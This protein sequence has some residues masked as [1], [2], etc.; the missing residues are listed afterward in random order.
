MLVKTNF[1]KSTLTLS[2]NSILELNHTNKSLC[3]SAFLM[4]FAQHG[5][6]QE[7]SVVQPENATT[8]HIEQAAKDELKAQVQAEAQTQN[9]S[10][11]EQLE[12]VENYQNKVSAPDSYVMLQ[13]Q[14]QHTDQIDTFKPITFDDL[15]ELPE[16]PID[17]N[18]ANEIYNVAKEAKTEAE[19]YRAGQTQEIVIRNPTSQELTEIN[20]APV[21]VD[22]LMNRIQAD[23]KIVV[24]ANESG[25]TLPELGLVTEPVVEEEKGFFKRWYH[26]LRPSKNDLET[27][28]VPRIKAEVIIVDAQNTNPDLP[29]KEYQQALLNLK[30]NVGAKLS[31]FTQEAYGDFNAALPQLKSLSNLSAQ[32]VGFYQAEFKFEKTSESRVKVSIKPNTPVLV[33]NQN[34]EFSGVGANSPQ[35]QVISVLPDLD[36]GD[37]LNHGL[38]ENTKKR[39]VDAAANNGYFDAYWRLHDVKVAQPQNLADINLRFETGER[40]KL[41]GAEFRMSDPAKPF[42]LDMDILKMM[43]PWEDGA[44]YALWRVNTLANNLTNSRYFNYTLVDAVRPDLV[45]VPLELPPDLQALV[46]QEKIASSKL[47]AQDQND[48]NSAKEVTQSVVDEDQFAGANEKEIGPEIKQQRAAQESRVEEDERLKIQARDEKKVPVIVTLNADRLNNAEVGAG[49]GSDTGARLRTTY[50]RA[51]VNRRGHSF[52]ANLELSQIRQAVDTRY[53]IPYNHPLNDYISLVG[54]YEREERDGVA[55]GNSLTIES[56]VVGADRIIKRSVGNWQHTFGLRYRL[57]RLSQNGVVNESD[58]PDAFLASSD[59]EQQ[60]LLAGYEASRVDSD[61]RVNPTKGFRQIYKVEV[62][63]EALLSDANMAILNAGWRFIYSLGENNDH[64]FIG[65]SDLGYIVTEDFNKIPYN[66]RYFAGGDQSIRGFDYKSLTPEVDGYKIGGQALAVGSLEYN[67]QFK[68]G[69]RAALFSDFGNAYDKDFSNDTEYS[70]GVGI[71]WASPI[72]ALRIDVASGISD[73][74]H[75]IRVHFFIGSPL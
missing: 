24:E 47:Q 50:R 2:M 69:W 34:I 75:P 57:D 67:Y 8:S 4:F 66:L 14:I 60:S 38:Y 65:R 46:D 9:L 73:E 10:R 16:T 18:M 17:Q 42:P 19:R 39:I 37:V 27:A 55:Q 23:S 70:V 29:D 6:A 56:A 49:W 72:G 61:K 54:G 43:V 15:E 7:M 68:D 3:L 58:I 63:S 28:K 48:V 30:N 44:D 13:D 22:Q 71:R 40:Y 11:A 33:D 25:K 20:Q 21:N 36:I 59:T 26:K 52:D 74:D 51:I 64:Q 12:K 35:F 45:E 5:F 62:G 31:S 53:N 1:K 41:A 32:A